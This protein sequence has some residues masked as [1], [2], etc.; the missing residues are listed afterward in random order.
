MP[1]ASP[2]TKQVQSICASLR[3]LEV[4]LSRLATV[5]KATTAESKAV[6]PPRRT[7]QLS[8]ARR[9][10]LKLQGQYLGYMRHLKR[11]QKAKVKAAKARKG[12]PAAI[13]MAKKLATRTGSGR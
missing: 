9:R 7:L 4:A 11:G 6:K 3:R 1:K 5:A 13:A 12:M 8:P 10:A 2:L